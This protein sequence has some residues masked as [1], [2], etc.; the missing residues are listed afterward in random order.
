[1][2]TGASPSQPS[3]AS[4][5]SI[6]DSIA[7][8]GSI[9]AELYWRGFFFLLRFDIGV[10][11]YIEA[12]SGVYLAHLRH[13][14]FVRVFAGQRAVVRKSIG[15]GQ[16]CKRNLGRARIYHT[17]RHDRRDGRTGRD[18]RV[19][20]RDQRL[21][22]H[23]GRPE[24]YC[25]SSHV[26]EQAVSGMGLRVSPSPPEAVKYSSGNYVYAR[27]RGATKRHRSI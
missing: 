22:M 25:Q 13:I 7:Q 8:S 5:R 23:A 2:P 4:N 1:M 24:F 9:G 16:S 19:T 26:R 6:K 12:R 11:P 20:A 17:E 15:I 3:R 18:A 10:P 21:D 14:I 27:R